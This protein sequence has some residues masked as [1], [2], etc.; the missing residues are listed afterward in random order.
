MSS[1]G[2]VQETQKTAQPVVIAV[3]RESAPGEQR[4][5]IVPDIVQKIVKAG[6]EVRIEH[7]AGAAAYY[8]DDLYAA[9]GAKIVAGRAELLNGARIVL[10]VQPPTVADID[11]LA[12]QTVVIGFMNP[13]GNLAAI[14]RMRDRKITAFSLEL[15]PRITRAQSMDALSSQATAG[16][17][18][19]AILGAENCP[20]FLPM[21]TTAAGTIRPATA[22][23]L[24]AGVAGLMAI[25]TARRLG[26]IVEAY[27]VRRA[28]GE[29]VRSLG[30][31]FLELE[32]NAEGQGG[33]ARELTAEEKVKEQEMV[34][35]AVAR[36]DIIITTA[37]IPG[38]KAPVLITKETVARMRPG[39][40]IID[41]A[42]ETGGN[43]EL[44]QAGKTI[45]EH[46]VMIIGPQNL[47]ARIPFHSSQM[48]AR[49]LHAF[50]SLLISKDGSL[51]GEFGDEILAASLLVHNGEVRYGPARDLLKGG[52][53]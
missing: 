25:A 26:A 10:R 47:P 12:E 22:L 34:S 18:V 42:A 24:G 16:G 45:R 9:A 19:A 23:I 44:T 30:A 28:A 35:A 2:T 48:Y 38:R 17:Y 33:Y 7:D 36:A 1:P 37:A 21:L 43:C 20:K 27:D 46:G 4:V 50:L 39:A 5:A 15:V 41:M 52:N 11:Q 3:P 6:H 51:I 29:Q 14:A 53:P 13:T 40:V 32:I 31:K 49:N 8:P